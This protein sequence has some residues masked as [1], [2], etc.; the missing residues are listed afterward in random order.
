MEYRRRHARRTIRFPLALETPAKRGR[1]GVARDVSVSG[2]LLGTPSRY[3][4][5]QRIRVR[6]RPRADGPTFEIPGTVVR[7][8]KNPDGD[9]LSR[10]VAIAFD[11]DVAEERVAEL[12]QTYTLFR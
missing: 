9:W 1:V 2:M 5:G 10:L 7:S 3:Q 11:R 8:E 6:F 12:D 4:L